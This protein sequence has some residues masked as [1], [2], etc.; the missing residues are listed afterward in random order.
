MTFVELQQNSKFVA[1]PNLLLELCSNV[2]LE[3]YIFVYNYLVRL[4]L[5]ESGKKG[6]IA[7]LRRFFES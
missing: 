2:R 6:G 4:I 1:G 5:E 7:C 3:R